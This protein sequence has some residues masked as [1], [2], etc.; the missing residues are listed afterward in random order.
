[1]GVAD[2]SAY[3]GTIGLEA[4]KSEQWCAIF[5][6]LRTIF[7]FIYICSVCVYTFFFTRGITTFSTA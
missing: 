5:D 1:V 6:V 7:V 2:L 4:A 3:K